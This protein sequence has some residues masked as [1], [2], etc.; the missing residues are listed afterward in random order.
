MMESI[1]RAPRVRKKNAYD[2][3]ADGV[4]LVPHWAESSIGYEV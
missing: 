4:T 3:T 1:A 2:A